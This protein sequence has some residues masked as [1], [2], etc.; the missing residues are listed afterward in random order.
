MTEATF[1]AAT[2]RAFEYFVD[3]GK[4]RRTEWNFYILDALAGDGLVLPFGAL[5]AMWRDVFRDALREAIAS[6]WGECRVLLMTDGD[7]SFAGPVATS[8]DEAVW[9]LAEEGPRRIQQQADKNRGEFA[10]YWQAQVAA[11]KE[12]EPG[13]I[14]EFT[15]NINEAVPMNVDP[16]A[17]AEE[18]FWRAQVPRPVQGGAIT[19]EM[20]QRAVGIDEVAPITPAEYARVLN[21]QMYAK[22]QIPREQIEAAKNAPPGRMWRLDGVTVNDIKAPAPKP[23]PVLP[24]GVRRYFDD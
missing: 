20:M 4:V 8:S 6:R 24:S 18:P 12:P 23:D 2:K 9:F 16:F 10:R 19:R 1:K 22:I 11:L 5:D 3:R 15:P 14:Q 17:R 13:S 21:R 7:E